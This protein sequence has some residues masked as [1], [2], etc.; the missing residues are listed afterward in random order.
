[1]LIPSARMPDVIADQPSRSNRIGKAKNIQN[2]RM[3]A[4][5]PRA[6]SM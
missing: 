3:I 5:T 2:S 6:N 4:L 1:M